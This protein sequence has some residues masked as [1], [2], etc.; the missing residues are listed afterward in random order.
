MPVQIDKAVQP[1]ESKIND[2]TDGPAAPS[3][4]PRTTME[5]KEKKRRII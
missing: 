5:K 2:P 3:D 4:D 1:F